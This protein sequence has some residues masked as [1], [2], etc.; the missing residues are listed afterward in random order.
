MENED[1]T[2]Y[3]V[4]MGVTLCILAFIIE[5]K[6]MHIKLKLIKVKVSSI[7][8][9]LELKIRTELRGFKNKEKKMFFFSTQIH[10]R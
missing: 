1:F 3:W 5:F 7:K 9:F 10:K 2:R 4:L 8:L 6:T